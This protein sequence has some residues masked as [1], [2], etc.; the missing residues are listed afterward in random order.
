MISIP[1]PVKT[2]SKKITRSAEGEACAL[3]V[4][5]RCAPRDTVVFCHAPSSGK[6]TS[7]KS[8]DWWG[9]YGC[10]NCHAMADSGKIS[11]ADWMTAVYETL[12]KLIHKGLIPIK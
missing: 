8:D 7:T 6:G 12:R 9:A 2:R 11:A 5:E 3:R 10:A 1:K 4:A